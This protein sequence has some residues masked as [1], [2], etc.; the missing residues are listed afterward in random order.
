MALYVRGLDLGTHNN[1]L[2]TM[3]LVR[4]LGDFVGQVLTMLEAVAGPGLERSL[5]SDTF[6][7]RYA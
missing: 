4:F 7:A 6:D 2:A 1:F 5:L 3:L